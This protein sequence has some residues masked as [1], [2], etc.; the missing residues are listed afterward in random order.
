MSIKKK[1]L[2]RLCVVKRNAHALN[3]KTLCGARV[4]FI[5]YYIIPN[6]KRSTAK[7]VM[8][9]SLRPYGKNA[10]AKHFYMRINVRIIIIRCCIIQLHCIRIRLTN[11]VTSHLYT[12]R[13][14]YLL[15]VIYSSSRKSLAKLK[16]ISLARIQNIQTRT[17]YNNAI[18]FIIIVLI[19]IIIY[20]SQ[21]WSKDAK[22]SF[23]RI[24]IYRN[25]YFIEYNIYYDYDFYLLR[26]FFSYIIN[27]Y[28]RWI[29]FLLLLISWHYCV[30]TIIIL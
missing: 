17:T 28:R 27:Y 4:S 26:F 21:K 1:K 3:V 13:T 23:Q 5:I 20:Y 15:I 16:N 11:D 18:I 14:Y 12:I 6:R 9:G 29:I 2:F 7:C 30:T 24:A 25:V 22:G 8:T 10:F 19:I